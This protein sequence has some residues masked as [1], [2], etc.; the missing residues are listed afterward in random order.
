[1]NKFKYFPIVQEEG[2]TLFYEAKEAVYY[3]V[4][5]P[6]TP[7]NDWT[8]IA[9]PLV[10]AGVRWLNGLIGKIFVDE[11]QSVLLFLF[12]TIIGIACGAPAVRWV[13]SQE[14][15]NVC[16]GRQ[17]NKVLISDNLLNKALKTFIRDILIAAG[18]VAFLLFPSL[19]IWSIESNCLSIVPM[20]LYIMSVFVA[21]PLFVLVH[22]ILRTRY[23]LE[24][25][26]EMKSMRS[27]HER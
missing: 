11:L 27:D 12:L 6:S 25:Y 4:T 14:R 18:V 21:W 17:L 10:W 23:L 1:M 24:R 22:P 19:I 5:K 16:K 26:S 9:L 15:T 13:K 20:L 7:N 8:F 2:S 3:S